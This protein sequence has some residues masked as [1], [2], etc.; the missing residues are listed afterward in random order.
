MNRLIYPLILIFLCLLNGVGHCQPNISVYAKVAAG[1]DGFHIIGGSHVVDTP[2][3]AISSDGSTK[4]NNNGVLM[5]VSGITSFA[6]LQ[7]PFVND[8]TAAI[9][10]GKTIYVKCSAGAISLLGSNAIGAR[11]TAEASLSQTSNTNPITLEF[12]VRTLYTADG[13]IYLAIRPTTAFRSVRITL[14]ALISGATSFNVFYAFYGPDP[15]NDTNPFPLNV[16]D[17]GLPNVTE[18]EVGGLLSLSSFVSPGNAIDNS[19]TTATTFSI[20]A[21]L[22]TTMKQTFYF[23]GVSNLEDAVRVIF[24]K[25]SAANLLGVD[26]GSNLKIQAFNGSIGVSANAVGAEIPFTD[27]LSLN[28]LASNLLGSSSNSITA[29]LTP[30]DGAKVFDRVVVTLNITASLLS[31]LSLNSGSISGFNIFDVR[32]VPTSPDPK[33]VTVCTNVGSTTLVA[34]STQSTIQNIGS[35]IYKWYN[36][37]TGGTGTIGQNLP[38]TGLTTIGQSNYYVD[39]QKS[40]C[41]SSDVGS[42]SGRS[43]VIVNVIN[44]PVAPPVALVP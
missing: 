2:S 38:L 15:T 43:K 31:S 19:L 40:G 4:P 13:G 29:Y 26:L 9:A 10:G 23:N 12:P 16:A 25:G 14:S 3:N 8:Q 32:R 1:S 5:S 44:P 17:C 6:W 42:P 30:K 34:N 39:V 24:S 27:L 7:L 20:T 18:T 41:V 36:V 28:L 22:V 37:L 21:G 33:T 11:I 35:L